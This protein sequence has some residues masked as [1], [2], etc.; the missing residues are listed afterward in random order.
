MVKMSAVYQGEKH[1][2]ATHEPSS[3]QIV[4]DAPKDNNGKGEAF[5]PTDLMAMSLGTCMLTT[6]AI[7]CEKDQVNIKGSRVTVE[8]EMAANPRRIAKLT[9]VLHLPQNIASDYRKKLESFALN[10]P[11]KFS[12][13]PDVQVPITFHYDM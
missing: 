6:M 8:K 3:S 12:L 10:C 2:E 1:C 4:T 13:H 11:A 9:V 7:H 5:S